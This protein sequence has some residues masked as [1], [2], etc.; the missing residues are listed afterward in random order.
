MDSILIIDKSKE[1][2]REVRDYW[3]SE[4]TKSSQ[5]QLSEQR[6]VQKVHMKSFK[7]NGKCK[8]FS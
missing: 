8:K 5:E 6:K 3:E 1:T 7:S 2:Y 4:S